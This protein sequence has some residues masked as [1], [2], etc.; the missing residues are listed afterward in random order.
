MRL[1]WQFDSKANLAYWIS[2]KSS[3]QSGSPGMFARANFQISPEEGPLSRVCRAL[4]VSKILSK[5]KGSRWPSI[6]TLNGSVCK[7]P[8]F[9]KNVI[10]YS[11]SK[12]MSIGNS[13]RFVA[14][15]FPT[16]RVCRSERLKTLPAYA[17]IMF[18]SRCDRREKQWGDGGAGQSCVTRS[19][20]RFT[21]T[22]THCLVLDNIPRADL[23][24]CQASRRL[25]WLR[26]ALPRLSS[27]E[28]ENEHGGANGTK[29]KSHSHVYSFEFNRTVK[30][31]I[32]SYEQC[33]CIEEDTIQWKSLFYYL[34]RDAIN[35]LASTNSCSGIWSY[36]SG[37]MRCEYSSE[38][39][40]NI[41]LRGELF[42][43]SSCKGKG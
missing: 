2:F 12:T 33:K 11:T 1:A 43:H 38:R 10:L 26:T 28:K 36:C 13:S 23:I 20:Y 16:C 6:Y 14:C 22:F 34:W 35:I 8:G 17:K 31:K 4:D 37:P 41:T 39:E 3:G 29:I 32:P 15:I 42:K 27:S 30:P 7:K 18:R 24:H 19:T 25:I 40:C 5:S 9:T 21:A